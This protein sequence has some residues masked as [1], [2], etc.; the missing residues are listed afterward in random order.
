MKKVLIVIASIVVILLAAAFIIPVV[1]KDDIKA[2]IDKAL[3]ESVN[4]DIVWDTDDFRLSLFSNFPNVTAGLNNFGVINRAPF[5]GQILFAVQEFEVEVDLFSLF[6]DQ[7]KINGIKLNHPEV[8]IKVLPDG[9]A[10]YDIAIADASSPADEGEAD[11]AAVKYNIGIDHW[12][13]KD[14]H[15]VYDDQTLPFRME[16]KNLQHSGSGDFTQDVFDLNTY[17]KVG[18]VDVNF[19]GTEYISGKTLEA[20]MVLSISDEYSRYTFKENAVK[21]NDFSLSFD[22]FLA[23]LED[24]S[25]DMDITYGTQENTFKSLLSLVPGVYT[26]DF[27]DIQTEGTLAFNGAVKGKYDSLNMPAF[28]LALQVNEA[29]FKYPDLP[30]AIKNINMDLLVDNKD[31]NIDNTTVHLKQFHM[32]FGKNPIDAK[33]LVKNL[34]NYDMDAEVKGNLNLGELSTMFP[35]EGMNMRGSFNI[36]LTA[37]GI[38]DSVKQVIPK[39]D[40]TMSLKDGYVKTSEFPYALENV[41]FESKVTDPTGK[42]SDFKAIV[43][44]FSMVMD[45]EPFKANLVLENLDNYTWNLSAKGGID[46]E[47]ITKVFPVEGM[48]LAGKINADIST[49]GRMSDLDAE[50][51]E[52]LPTSGTVTVQNFKYADKELPYDVTITS[53]TASFDPRQM[54]LSNYKGT[55]GKSDMSINGSISNYIGY[56]FGENQT[57]KGTMNFSS[58]LLDLNEFMTEEEEAAPAVGQEEASY[59]VIQVP[60]NIDFV[61]KSNIKTAKVMDMEITNATGD[62]IVRGGVANLSNLKFNLLGGAFVVNGAYDARDIEKPQYDFKLGIQDLSIQKAYQTFSL[63]QGFAPIA[64]NV[65]GTVSTDFNVKGLLDQE[66]MPDLKSVSGGGLLKVAQATLSDSKI[67]K[68]ITSLTKL[69]DTDNVTMKDVL[70]SV[71]IEDGKLKVKPFDVKLGNYKTTISGATAL[72]G[73][74]GYDLKMDVPAGKLGSQFSSFVSSYTG[75]KTDPNSTI[76]VTIGLGGTYDNPQPKLLMTD[77]KQEVKTAV[78]EKAKEEVKGAAT[79]LLD[80]V[81]DDKAKEVIG[82]I[83][84]GDKKDTTK[85]EDGDLKKQVEEEAKDKIKDLFKKKKKGGN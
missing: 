76:P 47:K 38:Y 21:V 44:N 30:T 74:I 73:S 81:K 79:D 39:I 15:V 75:G 36:D 69:E 28:N 70:M 66:M 16:L 2:S 65:N 9:T 49:A 85:T 34:Y 3:A 1:F 77:Q 27:G 67:V 18:S 62:I 8:F 41:N 43:N 59:G 48:T 71:T 46:L 17:T 20:N 14:G 4:A 35:M 83:L 32:D 56:M 84:G 23:L 61:L 7:I 63:V 64:K 80:E 22:G 52:K 11:T 24:G 29:M 26:A 13:I 10:N 6:G 68:G 42:M 58:T 12:E 40:A 55:V 50:R 5:E 25:M 31:G 54:T 53:A 60:E 37:S 72:D 19:D 82:N 33:M 78:K 57:I 45:G 51:Y